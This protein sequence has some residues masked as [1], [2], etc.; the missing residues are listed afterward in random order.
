MAPALLALFIFFIVLI[1]IWPDMR[2]SAKVKKDFYSQGYE[3]LR[4]KRTMRVTPRKGYRVVDVIYLQKDS[5]KY[6]VTVLCNGWL[7]AKDVCV[8]EPISIND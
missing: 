8:S 7:K 6:Y 2:I 5:K 1:I 3:K 4:C